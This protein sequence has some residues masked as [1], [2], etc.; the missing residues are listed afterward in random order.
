MSAHPLPPV[1]PKPIRKVASPEPVAV[2]EIPVAPPALAD[3]VDAAL[4]LIDDCL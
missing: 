1:P 4:D 2:P 3:T